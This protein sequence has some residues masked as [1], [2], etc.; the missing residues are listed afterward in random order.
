VTEVQAGTHP[1]LAF[2]PP[3]RDDA[4]YRID[5]NGVQGVM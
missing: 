3:K 4:M 2:P 5:N 1:D